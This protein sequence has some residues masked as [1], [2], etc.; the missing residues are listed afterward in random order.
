MSS[1]GMVTTSFQD[2][3]NSLITSIRD[4]MFVS[5]LSGISIVFSSMNNTCKIIQF[6]KQYNIVRY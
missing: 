3:F 2:K 4:S 1:F 6:L 5:I